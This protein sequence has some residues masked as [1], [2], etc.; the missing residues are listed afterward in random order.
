MEEK[1]KQCTLNS[2]KAFNSF[3]SAPYSLEVPGRKGR[4]PD[5]LGKRS[6][7]EVLPPLQGGASLL[8]ARRAHSTLGRPE[9][10]CHQ[11]TKPGATPR[12][13]ATLIIQ[14]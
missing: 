6:S 14:V 1:K 4:G 3:Q 7:W 8:G 12:Q 10:A 11:A 9:R 5:I 13:S 2:E